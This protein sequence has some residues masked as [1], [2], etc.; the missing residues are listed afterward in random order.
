MKRICFTGLFLSS[1]LWACPSVDCKLTALGVTSDITLACASE[2]VADTYTYNTTIADAQVQSFVRAAGSGQ[3]PNLAAALA[4]GG[5]PRGEDDIFESC[6]QRLIDVARPADLASR[7]HA[8]Q[9][10]LTLP[11]GQAPA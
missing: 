11:L 8:A 10:G 1:S 2:S 4:V 5:P 3:Y 6:I 9:H 7:R